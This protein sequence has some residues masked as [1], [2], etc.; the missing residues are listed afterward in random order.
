MKVFLA[1]LNPTV[2]DLPGNA[3]RIAAAMGRARD[4]GA[5]LLVTAELSLPG[6]PPR[7]LVEKSSFLQAQDEALA[8]LAAQSRGIEAIV[9]IVERNTSGEGRGLLNSAAVLREGRV[10]STVAKSLLPTYDV[11]DEDR[12]F[13]PA[14]RRVLQTLCGVPSGV[15]ICEDAWTQQSLFNRRLYTADPIAELAGQGARV[16][17]NVSASPFSLGRPALRERLLQEHAR[18]RGLPLICVNQVGGNDELLFDGSSLVVDSTGRTRVRLASFREDERLV[19]L[20]RLVDL[21]EPP[22][23]DPAPAEEA[24]PALVMGT[25]DYVRKCGFSSVVLGLS[26]GID[27]AVTAA[28]AVAALGA[29]R[30]H[31]VAMPAR[32]S[33]RQSVED[34]RAVAE[35]LGIDLR[36]IGID[37]MFQS[38]LDTVAPVFAG[39]PADVTEENLQARCRGVVLM[40]LSNKFG[41]LVLTT[42]NKSEMAVGYCTLY[43]DMS[44]GLAVLSDVPKTLVYSLGRRINRDRVVI[45]EGIFSKP[46]S[47]ELR[48]NQ[49]DQDSLPPYETLDAILKLAVEEGRSAEAIAAAGFDP[50]VVRSIVERVD[51]NEYKRR[52]AAPGLRITSKAFGMGRRM[53]IAQGFTGR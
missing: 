49:T 42:G 11:F 36:T 18:R 41:W 46:P 43:G 8:D 48:P 2:G 33:S 38:A 19:D 28:V 47:A 1:Q 16:L 22:G 52:Q 34:A 37:G 30:V 14:A 40:A 26:G 24:L 29:D 4:A 27:S 15:T 32:Y 45:P 51:R 53:P 10:V 13:Q 5:D 3:A 12:Y 35:A 9:G 31:G 17:F 25:A 20:D 39:L 50:A 44:G 23:H 6:Y 21:P 7:D